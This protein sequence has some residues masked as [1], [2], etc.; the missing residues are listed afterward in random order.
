[1]AASTGYDE[2]RKLAERALRSTDAWAT[3]LEVASLARGALSVLDELDA[4]AD[5]ATKDETT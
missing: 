5:A 3:S 4:L 2:L 1:M